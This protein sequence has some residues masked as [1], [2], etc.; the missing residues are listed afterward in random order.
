MP[1]GRTLKK[2]VPGELFVALAV[3]DVLVGMIVGGGFLPQQFTDFGHVVFAVAIAEE[4][5]VSDALQALGKNVQEETADEF[6]SFQRHDL[7]SRAVLVVF[8]V[9]G[10]LAIFIAEKSVV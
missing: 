9:E 4:A 6:V 8:P 3:V 2:R 7:V 1:A 5:E 10:D